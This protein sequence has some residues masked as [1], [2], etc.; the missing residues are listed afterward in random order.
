M[1]ADDDQWAEDRDH[2]ARGDLDEYGQAASS[3]QKGG[4]GGYL[5][6]YGKA[7]SR[8]DASKAGGHNYWG[9]SR[10]DFD[11]YGRDQDFHEKV[12]FDNT[13][14]KGYAA[15]SYD[16]W[17]NTDD[18]S[19]GAQAWGVD[20]DLQ[21]A[22]SY[23]GKS[24]AGKYGQSG[25]YG[26]AGKGGYG[27]GQ[28]A[29]A[30]GASDWEGASKGAKAARGAYDN[31]SWAKQAYGQDKDSR[32]GKSYDSVKARS[33]DGTKYARWLQADDDQWMEDRDVYDEGDSLSR[34]AAASTW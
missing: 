31:D 9:G 21:G 24:S 15:E 33:Y 25:A 29:G 20:K 6:G 27:K 32:Y 4:K 30:Y 3:A 18:D 16:E 22:S 23:S 1:I 10:D 7:G 5:G 2:Y 13:R 26:S 19:W 11:A 28:S 34:G 17:D 12:S 8:K 14:A